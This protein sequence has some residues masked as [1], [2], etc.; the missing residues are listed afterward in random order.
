MYNPNKKSPNQNIFDFVIQNYGTLEG[1]A[2]FLKTQSS[3][4]D[5]DTLSVGTVIVTPDRKENGTLN[6]I[7]K[8]R[9]IIA[10]N[11]TIQGD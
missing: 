9:I 10:T 7:L 6:T 2:A 1:L 3:L 8:N 4:T 11:K 5:F